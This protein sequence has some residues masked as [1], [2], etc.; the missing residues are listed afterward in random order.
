MNTVVVMYDPFAFESRISVVK[1]GHQ[2]QVNVSS[3][4]QQLA[5]AVIGCAYE[6]GIDAVKIHAPFAIYSEMKRVIETSEKTLY[7]KNT[8]DIG[9]I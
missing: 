8:L 2:E 7:N 6:H 3:D 5:E 9:V 1:D 4:I